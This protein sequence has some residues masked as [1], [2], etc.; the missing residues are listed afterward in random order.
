MSK[1]SA[2]KQSIATQLIR[3]VFAFYCIIALSVTAIHVVAEYQ[4]TKK[5]IITEL[6]SYETIF[7]S[8]LAKS[9]WNLDKEQ[10][11][12]IVQGM[13][14]IPVIVGIKVET[15]QEDNIAAA[16]GHII[17]HT[18]TLQHYDTLNTPNNNSL[19]YDEELFSYQFDIRY[20]YNEQFQ[21]LGTATLYSDSSIILNRTKIGFFFLIINAIIK[22]IAL[23]IIFLWIGRKLL[24]K[25]LALLTTAIN[26]TR[27]DTLQPKNIQLNIHT[28]NELKLIESTFNAMVHE[29]A[30]SKNDVLNFNEKLEAQIKVRTAE[31]EKAI[32]VA[33]EANKAK[34]AF[35]SRM[36]HE[37]RTPLNAII[38]FANI[39]QKRLEQ[40]ASEQQKDT[41]AHILKAGRHLLMLV[42]D[43]LDIVKLEEKVLD[44]D[45][46]ACDLN[47]CIQESIDLVSHGMQKNNLTINYTG[48]DLYILA[49]SGRLNQV[50]VNLLTNAIKYNKVDGYISIT[51]N[52]VDN[53]RVAITIT[54]TGV[55]IPPN[56]LDTIFQPFARL[57]YAQQNRID[58]TGIGLA[59][60]LYLIQGMGGEIAVEST[61]DEGSTFTLFFQRANQSDSSEN[62]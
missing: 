11:S 17:D 57:P 12:D 21:T 48:T 10:L 19:D 20:N 41:T 26:E 30:K 59:I 56:Q 32:E 39:K 45:L 16:L 1:H 24:L 38:G 43:I 47:K 55:G 9:L 34:T 54:D 25:P 15:S 5:T 52:E 31:L 8:V 29:L 13:S 37:L 27:F 18:G 53:N 6:K 3:V 40:D 49:D 2:V 28:Q 58:G 35:L 44:F 22:G 61:L 33:D 51:A 62:I 4:H 23:W 36:S 14:N 50:L 46:V 60:T 7:G 42:D